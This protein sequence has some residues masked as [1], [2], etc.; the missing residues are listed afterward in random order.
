MAWRGALDPLAPG[1]ENSMR[2]IIVAAAAAV[3]WTSTAHGQM[4]APP[5]MTL[6]ERAGRVAGPRMTRL[7]LALPSG[8]V[9]IERADLGGA[10]RLGALEAVEGRA[11][12]GVDRADAAA[13]ALRAG[14][15]GLG[16][17]GQ[18]GEQRED[19]D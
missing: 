11:Q 3:L 19:E 15:R 10:A 13:L 6:Y 5:K 14:G 1:R 17:H 2:M 7:F 16:R 12:A 9:E 4:A 18:D 8:G